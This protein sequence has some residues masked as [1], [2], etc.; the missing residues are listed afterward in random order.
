M[1][2]KSNKNSISVNQTSADRRLFYNF[3]LLIKFKFQFT[4]SH[5]V[6]MDPDGKEGS[7]KF[8]ISCGF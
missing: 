4:F 2:K 3:G 5:F 6:G 8:E 1:P 7:I